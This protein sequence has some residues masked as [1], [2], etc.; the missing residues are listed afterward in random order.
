MLVIE[1][2]TEDAGDPTEDAGDGAIDEFL[3]L[4]YQLEE[5]RADRTRELALLSAIGD[6]LIGYKDEVDQLRSKLLES[7]RQVANL[8]SFSRKVLAEK[9]HIRTEYE[10]EVLRLK[11]ELAPHA[12]SNEDGKG[13]KQESDFERRQRE[14]KKKNAEMVAKLGISKLLHELESEL[15]QKDHKLAEV[16]SSRKRA[17]NNGA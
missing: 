6:R 14:N 10:A 3:N 15:A 4:R 17:R 2:S 11:Q 16:D 8:F 5:S 1:L 13:K 7:E 9:D 12:S